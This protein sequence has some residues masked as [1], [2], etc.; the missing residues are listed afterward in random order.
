MKLSRMQVA[1]LVSLAIIM[2]G[3]GGLVALA[4]REQDIRRRASGGTADTQL[5]CD[6]GTK[7]Y[8]SNTIVV[9]NNTNE[10][11][12]EMSS[13]VFRCEYE[14]GRVR[15]GFYKCEDDCTGDGPDCQEG[16]WDPDATED[17]ILDPGETKTVSV[18]VNPCEIV[19]ID[20][21]NTV[22][23][24]LDDATECYNIQSQGTDPAPPSRWQGGIAFGIKQNSTGY[25]ASTGTCP[26]PSVSPSTS[27][28]VSPTT[29]VTPTSPPPV[30]P[31]NS[32]TPQ[33][34]APP[35]EPTYTPVPTSPPTTVCA[36]PNTCIP[37]TECTGDGRVVVDGSCSHVGADY[38]CCSPSTVTKGG[39]TSTPIPTRPIAGNTSVTTIGLLGALGLLIIGALAL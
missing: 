26:Q 35:G 5:V 34:T 6:A 36:P 28:S 2:V 32:P 11:L 37:P 30:S 29:P 14:P 13:R 25:D 22:D 27:P 24:A 31:T 16:V 4:Q 18:T 23:H 20:V 15:E 19:Q 33:P 7:A 21:E 1:S 39:V 38:V 10:R 8:D 3:L 17:F 9:T 12:E